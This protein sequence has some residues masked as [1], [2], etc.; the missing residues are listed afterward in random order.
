MHIVFALYDGM[1]PLDLVGPYEII[2][3]WPDVDVRFVA[4]LDATPSD[5]ARL[6]EAGPL[7]DPIRISQMP[8]RNGASAGGRPSGAST[9]RPPSSSTAR[10]SPRP[11]ASP[12]TPP[13]WPPSLSAYRSC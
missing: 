4:P 13:S 10:S 11:A 2:S 8:S 6:G 9:T 12:S 5:I 7:K 1:T 3:R